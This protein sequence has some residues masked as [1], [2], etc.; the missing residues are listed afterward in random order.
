MQREYA[1]SLLRSGIIDAKAGQNDTARQYLERA[2]YASSDHTLLAEAWYWM[3]KIA[4]DPVEQRSMLENCLSNDIRHIRARK[5]LA[6]LDGKL[7]PE[8]IV[9]PDSL[10]PAPE[11]LVHA[12]AKRFMCPKC[13]GRM[14]FA[15]DGHSL[16]C[17]FCARSQSL[18]ADKDAE[19]QDFLIAMATARGHRKPV[20]TQ[21]FRCQGCGAEFILPP[22]LISATCAY[23]G[24][25]HVVNL[26]AS[27]ELIQPEGIIPQA[28]QEGRASSLLKDW[29]EQNNISLHDKADP[30]HAVYLPIW[31]FDIG[32]AI[33]YRGDR[34][35]SDD[36]FGQVADSM[37]HVQDEYPVSI[38]D[39]PIPASR[40]SASSLDRLLPSFDLKVI[41]PYDQSYLAGWAAEV[42]DI[43][44]SSA[45][46]DARSRAYRE[47]KRDLPAEIGSLMNLVTSSANLSVESFKLVLLPV[48]IV[49]LPLQ[50]EQHTVLINGQNG[51]IEGETPAKHKA[52]FLSWLEDLLED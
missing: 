26:E 24:S 18:G 7:K 2:L 38:D 44:L 41:N 6:V 10:P 12:D 34:F 42:Y 39:L 35:E 50:G 11:E 28:F 32:G 23:C 15:P 48:W 20:A 22:D 51:I 13:G 31:T 29:L 4:D 27:R 25:P 40:K 3:S 36:Q 30:P 52:S 17:E 45:S 8:E 19:E 1:Q 5:D 9:D 21:V 37:I 46:L 14:V 49:R 16:V 47:L 33:S 43:P